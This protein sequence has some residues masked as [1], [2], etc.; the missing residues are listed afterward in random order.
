MTADPFCGDTPHL[1]LGGARS[2]K[3]R[4]AE[5]LLAAYRPPYVY[6]ATAEILDDEMRQRVDLHR[7]R[8]GDVWETIE[9]PFHLVE[10]LDTLRLRNRPV[11]VDCLTLWMS[12]VLLRETPD[13]P[14]GIIEALADAL[15]HT[16]YPLILVSNEVGCGIVPENALA[17]RFRDLAGYLNQK[18]AGACRRVTLVSAGLPLSLK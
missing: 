9:C 12:N 11:L 16:T 3:S 14:E 6:V 7:R 2:G 10:L 5:S 13:P 4:F 18:T 15:R 17:R 1:V 8:R